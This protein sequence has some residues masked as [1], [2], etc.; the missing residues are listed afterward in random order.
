MNSEWNI[1]SCTDQCAACQ[2]KFADRETL[3]SR[4]YFTPDGYLRED[5]C[6][7]CWPARNAGEGA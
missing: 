3:M 7:A 1:R 2:K 4:L 5:F 6:S